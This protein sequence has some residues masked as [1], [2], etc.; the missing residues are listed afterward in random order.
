MSRHLVTRGVNSVSKY[1]MPRKSLLGLT[2]RH[3]RF[4]VEDASPTYL[5]LSKEVTPYRRMAYATLSAPALIHHF[6]KVRDP[7]LFCAIPW[8]DQLAVQQK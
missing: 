7:S 2:C 3:T 4:H 5:Y 8:V 1:S 6:R